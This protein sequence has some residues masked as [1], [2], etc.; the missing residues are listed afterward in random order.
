MTS[1]PS[2]TRISIFGLGY[3][4]A[5][6]AACL[7]ERG[8]DVIGVDVS[9]EKVDL[10]N[11]GRSPI[12]EKGIEALIAAQ[13]QSGR[14]SAT[15]KAA[16]AVLR[17]DLSIICV[18]TPS[19]PNGD[20][21]TDH[22]EDVSRDI[23]AAIGR[24]SDYH[25]VVLRSTVLPGVTR[26]KVLPLL[27]QASGKTAGKDFGVCFNPEF[28]R[29]ATAIDDFKR[30]P[31][32]IV[33]EL[34]ARSGDAVVALY[35][36]LPAPMFRTSIETAELAKYADNAW[37]ALKVAY[38]NEIGSLCKA[39]D[40][41][42][43]ELMGM[44][45]QDTKLNLSPYYMKPGFIF[46]GSCLPKDLRAVV[47]LARRLDV[48]TPVLNSIIPS[49]DAHLERALDI[50]RRAGAR[51]IGV[52]GVSF[53][54]GTDD[55]RESP[56]VRL[57]EILRR[58]KFAVVAHDENFSLDRSMG[59]NRRF[60]LDRVPDFAELA[61]PDLA[62]LAQKADV[63]VVTQNT[64]AHRAIVRDRREGQIVIDLVHLGGQPPHADY[65]V[66]C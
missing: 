37:H 36:D 19:M 45:C 22:A 31:K 18:G 21:N 11:H 23:G 5:V 13:V 25:V 49:N 26:K 53:K 64:S 48:T 63:L 14:L 33:G 46:G 28:L 7:A 1:T 4:G 40:I 61:A 29:E 17:S 43:H 12:V 59:D 8:H 39:V 34:D 24:K 42:S 41:D 35:A 58:E 62:T 27:E 56:A 9:Q 55:V 6:T 66:L 57:I 47:A 32:T 16:D 20:L 15:T 44:F 2:P 60:L 38:A 50:I 54:P 30:P 3:V 52:L 10:I 65:H 51:T